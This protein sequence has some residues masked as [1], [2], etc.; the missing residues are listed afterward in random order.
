[1]LTAPLLQGLRSTH[2][3]LGRM[4]RFRGAV[5]QVIMNAVEVREDFGMCLSQTLIDH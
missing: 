1:M 5:G 3:S 2:I 4:S